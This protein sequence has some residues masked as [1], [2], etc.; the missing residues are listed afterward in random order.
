L[1]F[2]FF[3]NR[4]SRFGSPF[5]PHKFRRVWK[6]TIFRLCDLFFPFFPPH[7]MASNSH[8]WLLPSLFLLVEFTCLFFLLLSTVLTPSIFDIEQAM[9]NP[10]PIYGHVT[11]AMALDDNILDIQAVSKQTQK[12]KWHEDNWLTWK[13]IVKSPT[14]ITAGTFKDLAEVSNPFYAHM[15]ALHKFISLTKT[16]SYI[17]RQDQACCRLQGRLASGIYRKRS[18][19]EKKTEENKFWPARYRH[20]A[21]IWTG[22]RLR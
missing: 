2:L 1:F 19:K 10:V 15:L 17:F 9:V 13:W 21:Q 14:K 8:H 4:L 18:A 16:K 3:P 20:L 7:S 11:Q 12:C 6:I 5:F 22:S